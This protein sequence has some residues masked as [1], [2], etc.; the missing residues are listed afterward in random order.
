[1]FLLFHKCA[2]DK[3]HRGVKLIGQ[4]VS[5][6][7]LLDTERFNKSM[8]AMCCTFISSVVSGWQL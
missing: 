1:M 8:H 4:A 6:S 2:I 3:S 7:S 5:S